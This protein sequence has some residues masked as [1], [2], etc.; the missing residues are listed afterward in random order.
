MFVREI[1]GEKGKKWREKYG[2]KLREGDIQN[3][4]KHIFLKKTTRNGSIKLCFI[5]PDKSVLSN[6]NE[7]VYL[8]PV[9]T[10]SV[11]QLEQCVEMVYRQHQGRQ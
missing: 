2:E 1:E 6:T 4:K 5:F 7:S 11:G 8:L 3:K 9:R 10:N